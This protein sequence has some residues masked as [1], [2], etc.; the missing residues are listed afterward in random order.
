MDV[1]ELVVLVATRSQVATLSSPDLSRQIR[2][3]V[4]L[5]RNEDGSRLDWL[6]ARASNAGNPSHLRVDEDCS[7]RRGHEK[8]LDRLRLSDDHSMDTGRTAGEVTRVSDVDGAGDLRVSADLG[9]TE[10]LIVAGSA[11]RAGIRIAGGASRNCAV[12]S[13]TVLLLTGGARETCGDIR[14]SELV[15]DSATGTCGDIQTGKLVTVR[16]EGAHGGSRAD[17]SVGLGGVKG[18]H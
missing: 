4:G 3:R 6:K 18:V 1:Q 7:S 11:R 15:D 12:D 13:A 5:D 17:C 14:S 16:A 8:C 9:G 2:T 10:G